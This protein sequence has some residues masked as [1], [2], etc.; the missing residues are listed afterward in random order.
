MYEL[1]G[2]QTYYSPQPDGHTDADEEEEVVATFDNEKDAK[3]Y[4]K[5]SRLKQRKRSN[6]D[7]GQ[8][9]KSSSLLSRFASAEVRK[10]YSEPDPPHNPTI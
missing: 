1:V 5:K 10:H 3:D 2:Y 9:F 4:I 8:P 7:D 6:W